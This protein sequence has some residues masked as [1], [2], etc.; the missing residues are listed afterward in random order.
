MERSFGRSL[1]HVASFTGVGDRLEP[2]GAAA[3]AMDS[4]VAF[5]DAAPR[6][7]LVAHELAHVLQ[8]PGGSGSLVGARNSGAEREADTIAAHI[9]AHGAGARLPP[10][11]EARSATVHMYPGPGGGQFGLTPAQL[12][13]LQRF[14]APDAA[15]APPPRFDPVLAHIRTTSLFDIAPSASFGSMSQ[16]GPMMLG[17]R[18][19][20]TLRAFV[21]ADSSPAVATPTAAT[22][23]LA[24]GVTSGI[25]APTPVTGTTFTFGDTLGSPTSGAHGPSA[26]GFPAPSAAH[27]TGTLDADLFRPIRRPAHPCPN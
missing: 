23:A 17:D 25:T 20:A 3:I 14:M 12:S 26:F 11:C 18:D 6:P 21:E 16:V 8:R 15:P 24:S 2:L 13:D 5:S 27:Q 22:Q 9:D 4:A 19:L 1:S 10:I 7:S